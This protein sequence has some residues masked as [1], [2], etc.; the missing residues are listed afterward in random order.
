MSK[1]KT[2]PAYLH[3]NR[4]RAPM[5]DSVC[6]QHQ[7]VTAQRVSSCA[8]EGEGSCKREIQRH[9][10]K[11]NE[12]ERERAHV[13]RER[14][15]ARARMFATQNTENSLNSLI[16]SIYSYRV[17]RESARAHVCNAKHASHVSERNTRHKN[18]L[19]RQV[20]HAY[21]GL[22]PNPKH[23]SAQTLNP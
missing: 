12:R 15:R 23:A 5:V 3:G 8:M 14:E 19:C 16:S 6:G 7:S 20:S 11:E 9:R 17:C 2:P 13:W 4:L 22:C 21:T 18:V 1:K 10:E